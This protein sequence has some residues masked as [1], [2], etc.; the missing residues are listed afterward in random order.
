MLHNK[1]IVDSK[2][3]TETIY[4]DSQ[5]KK[6]VDSISN[7][8]PI[9]TLSLN[10]ARD[11]LNNIQKDESYKNKIDIQHLNVTTDKA[12]I[13]LDIF[14][15]KNNKTKLPI[16]YYVHGGGWILGNSQT[17]GRLVTEI[18]IQTNSAVVF[19]NYSPAPEKKYPTQII[20]GLEGL[21][22]VYN[23][24]KTLNLDADNIIIMGDSVGGNMATVI[25]MLINEKQGPK[26]KYQILAYPTIDASM[27]T[28][29]YKKYARGPWLTQQSMK[30]FYDA[31]ENDANT[32][33]NPTISPSR[34]SRKNISELP[35]TLIIVDENDVL[36]DEGEKYA[37]KLMEA[38]VETSSVRILGVIHDF[39]MLDPLKDSPNVK[40]AMNIITSKIRD[41]F[42]GKK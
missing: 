6:F 8:K 39:L 40:T 4:L 14:R 25:A 5:T 13:D 19:I 9:Y 12:N 35:P 3:E 23:N 29:S 15:P 11:V 27:N 16:V 10:D 33:L 7:A 24:A 26:L 32:R 42:Y 18:A 1:N 20:Q 21:Y 2:K 41:I 37:Y 22:Y 28:P 17:H 36:R 31:Y 30:W 34:A 38:G